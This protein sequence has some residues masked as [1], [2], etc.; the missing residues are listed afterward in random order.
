M[1][2]HCMRVPCFPDSWTSELYTSDEL[3]TKVS[4]PTGVVSD[5]ESQLWMHIES[6]GEYSYQKIFRANLETFPQAVA[7]ISMN[8]GVVEGISWD[9]GCFGCAAA[10]C[11]KNVYR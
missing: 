4:T 5:T 7:V 11:K 3:F 10:D 9:T 2:T 8:K 6:E 1:T